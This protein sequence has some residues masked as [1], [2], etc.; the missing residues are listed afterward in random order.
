MSEFLFKHYCT[1]DRN[2]FIKLM[3]AEVSTP[4]L[5]YWR[6]TKSDISYN[7]FMITFFI[8]RIIYHGLFLIPECMTRCVVTIGYGFG[9]PYNLMNFYFFFMVSNVTNHSKYVKSAIS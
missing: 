1:F 2:P 8:F 4:F 7:I 9:I 3:L 6:S 5:I